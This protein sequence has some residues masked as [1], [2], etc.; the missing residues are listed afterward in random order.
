M[1]ASLRS[2]RTSFPALKREFDRRAQGA[3]LRATHRGAIRLKDAH[4][5]E[6]AAAGLGRLGMALGSGSDLEKGG[7]IHRGPNGWSVSGWVFVRSGSK[8]SQGALKAYTEGAKITPHNPS[9]LLWYPTDDIMRMAR[10][11][12]PSTGGNARA[13]VRLTP[14]LWRR[15]YQAR[16]G[17]LVRLPG[18][19]LLAVKN[20]T[21]SLAGKPRSIKPLTKRGKVPKGQ[22]QRDMVIAFIGIPQTSRAARVNPEAIARKVLAELGRDFTTTMRSGA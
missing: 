22:V 2:P 5:R 10:V 11:P 12:L 17:P 4:R 15:V 14:S 19:N 3:A 8:R 13:N 21:L 1:I 16:F 9:G 18:T 7:R 6:M 20:T